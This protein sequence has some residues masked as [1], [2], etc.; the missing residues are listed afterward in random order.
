MRVLIACEE[1]QVVCTAFRNKG[2]EAYSC[3]I[4]DCSGGH[5]EWHIKDDVLKHLNDGWDMMIAH[6]PCTYLA[7]S[8]ARWLKDNPDRYKAMIEAAVF[9]NAL[10]NAPIDKIAVENPMQHSEARKLIRKYDQR[11]KP[12]WF[13]ETA[14]K[15]TYLWFKNLPP[16]MHTLIMQEEFVY[17]GTGRKWGKWFWDTSCIPYEQRAKARSKTFPRIAEAMAAQWSS[18]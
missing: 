3:D 18:L 4:Q 12:L 9:F 11:I 14:G 1:S 2:H 10:L 8:G 17:S 7:M 13:G 6:P 16:L 15:Q 5:P